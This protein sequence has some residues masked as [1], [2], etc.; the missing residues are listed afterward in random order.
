MLRWTV[1]LGLCVGISALTLHKKALTPAAALAASGMLILL[2]A[3][4][5]AAEIGA[6]LGMYLTV[7]AADL[8]FGKRAEA[9]TR[10]VY[11]A[12]GPRG[13]YQIAAN[14]SAACLCLVLWF[15]SGQAAFRVGYYTAVYEILADSLASDVGVLSRRPPRDI[16][17]WRPVERGISGGVSPLGLLVSAG[18][19]TAAGT[20]TGVLVWHRAALGAVTALVPFLGMLLDSVLGSRFQVQY[21][22]AVC[23]APTERHTHCGQPVLAVRGG[24]RL[25]NGQVNFLCTAFA[26]ALG[27]ALAWAA[28]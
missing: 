14:G 22:C 15:G 16:C 19:C 17:T 25:S 20:L 11:E 27:T 3:L 9:A 24:R 7:F 26:A 2:T 12:A 4:G 28:V 23:G 10:Q 18:A 21:R 13:F 8:A 1:T 6:L 5:G